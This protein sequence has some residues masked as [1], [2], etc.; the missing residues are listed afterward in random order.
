MPD[1]MKHVCMYFLILVI[2]KPS[3]SLI[4]H[5]PVVNFTKYKNPTVK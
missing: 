4:H 5:N 1:I 2:L 3:V